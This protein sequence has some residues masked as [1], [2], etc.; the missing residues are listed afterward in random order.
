MTSY[1]WAIALISVLSTARNHDNIKVK[2]GADKEGGNSKIMPSFPVQ[3]SDLQG[4]YKSAGV[5]ILSKGSN[6][7][8]KAILVLLSPV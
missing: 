3:I 2:L 4:S 8:E 1:E 6:L 5:Q 7:T